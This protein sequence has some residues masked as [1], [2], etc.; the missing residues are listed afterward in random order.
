MA[1][2]VIPK[3]WV[4]MTTGQLTLQAIEYLNDLDNGASN[5]INSV[6]TILSGV[7]TTQQAIIAGTQP[8]TDVLITSVGSVSGTLTTQNQNVATVTGAASGGALVAT[9]NRSAVTGNRSGAGTVTTGTVTVTAS[10]GTGPY[11]YAW[12]NVSGDTFTPTIPTGATTAFSITVAVDDVKTA[13]YRCTVT[14]SV[15]A[16]YAVDVSVTAFELTI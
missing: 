14:D 1:K 11:T 8:L 9:L 7:N 12:T 16:T 4:D 6:G 15:A 13:Q 3:Q 5:S 2:R 10:G